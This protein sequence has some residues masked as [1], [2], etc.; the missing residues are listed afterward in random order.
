MLVRDLPTDL[1][2][3]VGEFVDGPATPMT[4]CLL[5]INDYAPIEEVI[6]HA[7]WWNFRFERFKRMGVYLPDN[8]RMIRA[9]NFCVFEIYMRAR[10][11]RRKALGF[12]HFEQHSTFDRAYFGRT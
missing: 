8:L 2:R 3:L 1:R 4:L 10:Y 11:E 9:K 6:D 5:A 12:K 7:D